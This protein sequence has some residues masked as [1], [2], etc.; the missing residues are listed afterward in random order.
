MITNPKVIKEAM[1]WA[2][3]LHN[4]LEN[5]TLSPSDLYLQMG[6]DP[7]SM[8]NAAKER[9][10]DLVRTLSKPTTGSEAM[11]NFAAL[12]MDGFLVGLLVGDARTSVVTIEDGGHR[13]GER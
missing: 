6:L 8:V 7:T 1:A 3:D 5:Q 4:Q 2:D 13:T 9:L 12:W 11:D 10:G